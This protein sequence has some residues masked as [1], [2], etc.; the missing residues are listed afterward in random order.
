[1]LVPLVN[2]IHN[3]KKVKVNGSVYFSAPKTLL[4][5]QADVRYTHKKYISHVSDIIYAV[6]VA[7]DVEFPATCRV[8]Q[9]SFRVGGFNLLVLT[10]GIES[11]VLHDCY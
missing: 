9:K 8:R 11:E 6:D 7:T 5:G 1:M 4:P 10:I 2:N 3:Q